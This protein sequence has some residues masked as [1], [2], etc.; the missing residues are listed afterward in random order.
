MV[1]VWDLTNGAPLGAPLIGHS[2]VVGAVAAAV[3]PDGRPVAVTGG[4]DAT[5]RVWDLTNGAPLGEPL[6][7][8]TDWVWAAAATVLPNGHPVAVTG[9]WDNTV[10]IWKLDVLSEAGH[11]LHVTA[12]VR[13]VALSSVESDLVVVV[14]GDGLA[15]VDLKVG[16]L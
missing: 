15:R 11:P 9:S 3:L 2:G 6:V 10:R 8:H 1:R 7:G 13:G 16:A 5:V 12:P 14:V 4:R